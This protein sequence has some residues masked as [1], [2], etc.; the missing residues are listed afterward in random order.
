MGVLPNVINDKVLNDAIRYADELIDSDLRV[1]YVLPMKTI[2]TVLGDMAL[3]L[4]T[5]RLYLR[6]PDG[7]MPRR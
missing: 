6:R 1:R 3:N 5:Y 7:Q 2:P 4:V